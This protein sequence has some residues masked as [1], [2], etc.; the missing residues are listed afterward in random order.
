MAMPSANDAEAAQP[1]GSFWLIVAAG[2]AGVWRAGEGGL[3]GR[4][5]PETL[6]AI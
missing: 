6:D 2:N 1:D 3:H 5:I 4:F